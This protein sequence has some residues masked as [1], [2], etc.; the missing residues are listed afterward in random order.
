MSYQVFMVFKGRG[1]QCM[2][3]SNYVQSSLIAIFI[4]IIY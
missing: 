4:V 3:I 1:V 2:Y